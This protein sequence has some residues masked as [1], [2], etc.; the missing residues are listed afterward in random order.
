[1]I[2]GKLG[3][4]ASNLFE[5]ELEGLSNEDKE[6]ELAK[7]YV[8]FA[9][10]AVRGAARNPQFSRYPRQVAKTA[11]ISSARRYAPGLLRSRASYGRGNN[12]PPAYAANNY[13]S[14]NSYNGA[15]DGNTDESSSSGTWYKQGNQLIINLQ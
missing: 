10:N 3:S 6:F 12:R 11:I 4:Y 5:M 8:R 9:S 1:M 2:G 13:N 15:V 14:Y 7:A